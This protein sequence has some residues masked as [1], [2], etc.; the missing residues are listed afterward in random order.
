M[1]IT[2]TM[3]MPLPIAYPRA[4]ATTAQILARSL[5]NHSSSVVSQVRSIHSWKHSEK[6]Y[7]LVSSQKPGSQAMPFRALVSFS[8]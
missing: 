4:A 3:F 7:Y 8:F 1:G 6:T 2:S 5:I